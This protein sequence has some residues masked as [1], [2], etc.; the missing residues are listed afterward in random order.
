MKPAFTLI[1]VL[2]ASMIFIVVMTIGTAS[3]L[4][5]SRVSARVKAER[6]VVQQARFAM[7]TLIRETRTAKS[8]D[9]ENFDDSSKCG[10]IVSLTDIDNR[11]AK[12]EFVNDAV[13]RDSEPIT[14]KT[15]VLVTKATF[16]GSVKQPDPSTALTQPYLDI[17]LV[18]ASATPDPSR[19]ETLA[20]YELRSSA[21]L[22]NF[23]K[24]YR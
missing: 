14:D 2:I 9:I 19:P 11:T 6:E 5:S 24:E 23:V 3:F 4:G 18:V 21:T 13:N 8:Y 16:C 12:Y 15:V 10:S 17:D 22:R 20:A 1:E 7:E